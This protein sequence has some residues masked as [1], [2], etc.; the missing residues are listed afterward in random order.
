MLGCFHLGST[1]W[2][3]Y[4]L[5][6]CV[7]IVVALAVGQCRAAQNVYDVSFGV[8]E[9]LSTFL[10]PIL[11]DLKSVSSVLVKSSA[12]GN[13]ERCIYVYY[14]RVCVSRNVYKCTHAYGLNAFFVPGFNI[15]ASCPQDT[16]LIIHEEM[17]SGLLCLLGTH[18]SV[19]PDGICCQVF[20]RCLDLLL[21][22][23]LGDSG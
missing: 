16:Q 3:V 23:D 9:S 19:G 14:T 5:F 6:L 12:P 2:L 10:F 20:G 4:S 17:I 22:D 21:S 15:R 7:C 8:L 11:G 1:S 13:A 18:K